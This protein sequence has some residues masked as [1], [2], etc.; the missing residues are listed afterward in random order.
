MSWD[1]RREHYRIEDD[2]CF[3]YCVVEAKDALNEA[4]ITKQLLGEKGQ[5]YQEV[6]QYFRSIDNQL[7]EIEFMASKEEQNLVNYLK[8]LNSKIDYLANVLILNEN[9]NCSKVNLSLNGMAFKT[10]EYLPEGTHL[11]LRI[12]VKPKYVPIILDARVVYCQFNADER[13]RVAISFLGLSEKE[14][15]Y[16]NQHIM[17]S[18]TQQLLD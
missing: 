17:Y 4:A 15:Q 18:Q 12:N 10:T 13:Y 6:M 1:E 8:L 7:S 11:K 14:E 9:Q 2:L 5:N 16:L 3:A